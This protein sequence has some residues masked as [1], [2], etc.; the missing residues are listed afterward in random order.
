MYV[1]YVTLLLLQYYI[2]IYIYIFLLNFLNKIL[3]YK[4]PPYNPFENCYTTFY[5]SP[6]YGTT[7]FGVPDMVPN[8]IL[9]IIH[10]LQKQ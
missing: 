1:P 4:K 2:Y 3:P 5:Y 8:T 7:H 10:Y 6:L 9:K